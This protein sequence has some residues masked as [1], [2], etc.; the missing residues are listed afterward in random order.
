MNGLPERAEELE[1]LGMKL[2]KASTRS[3]LVPTRSNGPQ[4]SPK[5]AAGL[6]LL[7]AARDIRNWLYRL[8]SPE[9]PGSPE[10]P[11]PPDTL[12]AFRRKRHHGA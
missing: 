12:D 11:P 1:A 4:M 6:K 2:I 3:K 7:E 9:G 8:G 5:F 10:K